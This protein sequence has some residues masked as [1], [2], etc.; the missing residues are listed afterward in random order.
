MCQ[1]EFQTRT[2]VIFG[3]GA[4]NRLGA[5]ARDLGF[6]RPLLVADHGLQASGHVGEASASLAGAGIEPV[7]F[8]DFE[9]NPDTLMVEAGRVFAAEA[10][11]DSII[12]LGGGSSMD[13]AKAINFV[14]T[15]G[16]SMRDYHGFGKAS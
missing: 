9:A 16:G 14:L 13:C 3:E 8:H 5:V 6:R 15:N 2:R 10:G 1:F 4:I 12:G 11:I 7:P